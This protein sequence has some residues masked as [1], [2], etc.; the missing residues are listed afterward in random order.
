MLDKDFREFIELLN[1]HSVRYLI[2]GGYAV[3]LHGHP[4]MT[5][6]IDF[7]VAPSAEN[8]QRIAAALAEFGFAGTGLSAG[9]F[10]RT[11]QVVQLGYSPVRID[12]MTSISGSTF[13][14]AWEDRVEGDLDGLPVAYIGLRTLLANKAAT[15]RP[16][17]LADIDALT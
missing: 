11:G 5:G 4:R 17:D 15:G 8:A 3:A 16:K 7:L 2:V 1:A 9:D 14:E 13:D 12:L 6:D 10:A